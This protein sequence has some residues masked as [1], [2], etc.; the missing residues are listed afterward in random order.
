LSVLGRNHP[1]RESRRPTTTRTSPPGFPVT[2]QGDTK[3]AILLHPQHQT[4]SAVGSGNGWMDE[5]M[6]LGWL[7]HSFLLPLA[8]SRAS[9]SQP[10]CGPELGVEGAWCNAADSDSADSDCVGTCRIT[11]ERKSRPVR[12]LSFHNKWILVIDGG[13]MSFT[14]KT[15]TTTMRQTFDETKR[16]ETKRD[17]SRVFCFA[18]R[19]ASLSRIEIRACVCRVFV[20]VVQ[21]ACRA[22]IPNGRNDCGVL[23][24]HSVRRVGSEF[25]SF[26]F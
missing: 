19:M 17:D 22:F 24:R 6:V 2:H 25:L 11:R 5:W 1:E 23:A 4:V 18:P 13:S 14:T 16:D 10:P 15:K 12:V 3:T 20:F 7:V 8:R 9:E 26:R 21:C